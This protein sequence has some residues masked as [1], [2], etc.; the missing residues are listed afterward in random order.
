MSAARG[1]RRA[2]AQEL[3]IARL[4]R[5]TGSEIYCHKTMLDLV[6]TLQGLSGR[7][8]REDVRYWR[9][10]YAK[11]RAAATDAVR[12]HD[13]PKP[14]LADAAAW[15]QAFARHPRSFLNSFVLNKS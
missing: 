9:A 2:L 6:L 8:S 1:R 10:W 4:W 11:H 5:A 3:D 12:D 7:M 13:D 15:I 14:A